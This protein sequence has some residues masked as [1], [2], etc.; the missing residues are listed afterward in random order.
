MGQG[1][2]LHYRQLQPPGVS[3]KSECD[4][5]GSLLVSTQRVEKKKEEKKVF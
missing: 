1:D 3:S 5:Q 4:S 2:T